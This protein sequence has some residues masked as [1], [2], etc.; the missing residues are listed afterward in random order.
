MVETFKETRQKFLI[1]ALVLTF[2]LLMTSAIFAVEQKMSIADAFFYITISLE[3]FNYR[4]D[5]GILLLFVSLF[6]GVFAVYLFETLVYL[7]RDEFGGVIYM[8]QT[9]R[10]KDHYIICG[11]GRIGQHVANRLREKH[12]RVIIV[13]K[14]ENV[15]LELKNI[16]YKVLKEN[17]LEEKTFKMINTSRAKG[18]FACLGQDVDNFI[19]ILNAKAANKKVIVIS[20]CNSIKNI[21]KFKNLGADEVVLPEIAG[22][23]R[24]IYLEEHFKTK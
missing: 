14:D 2:I 1:A 23:D 3:T 9:L 24:M 5:Y 21:S 13:E 11:G 19:V 10:L 15:A 16:G 6:I 7:I 12:K 20:R 4:G 8:A 18:V 22:A 17:V